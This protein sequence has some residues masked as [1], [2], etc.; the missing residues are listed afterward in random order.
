M[1]KLLSVVLALVMVL[2]TASMLI[3]TAWAE[4]E[5]SAPY[6]PTPRP[7]DSWVYYEQDFDDEALDGLE[8]VALAE[9]IEWTA[10]DASQTMLLKD[11]KLRFVSQYYKAGASTAASAYTTTL[12]AEGDDR[13]LGNMTV[14]EYDLRFQRRAPGAENNVTVNAETT[15]EK[16][17][18]AD[19]QDGAMLVGV[20]MGVSTGM[21]QATRFPVA[22]SISK[23][24]FK[25]T[26]VS[27]SGGNLSYALKNGVE[28]IEDIPE[29]DTSYTLEFGTNKNT[30]RF[31]MDYHVKAVYDP[32]AGMY[33]LTLNGVMVS[34]VA[35]DD[36][37]SGSIR[38]LVDKIT[39]QFVLT[40]ENSADVLLDNIQIY[41][42][43][44]TPALVISEVTP[45]GFGVDKAG[46]IKAGGYQWIELYNPTAKDVNVYDYALH[47]NNAPTTEASNFG[48]NA[49]VTTGRGSA[50]GYFRAGEQTFALGEGTSTFVNPD[51]ADGVLKA[52]ESAIVLLPGTLHAANM[53]LNGDQITKAFVKMGMPEDTKIF[54]CDNY[55]AYP[56]V[57]SKE[58]TMTLGLM[59]VNNPGTAEA[60]GKYVDVSDDRLP[61]L[62][63]YLILTTDEAD[64]QNLYEGI[65]IVSGY[66]PTDSVLGTAKRSVEISYWGFGVD[67][68]SSAM[69]FMK[70]NGTET[71]PG[72]DGEDVYATPGYVGEELRPSVT[73]S[74]YD[75]STGETDTKYGTF[76]SE[77]T[78]EDPERPGY[79]FLGYQ[80]EGSDEYLDGVYMSEN[81]LKVTVAYKRVAPIFV[82]AQVSEMNEGKYTVRLL[83]GLVHGDV[84]GVGFKY[85][86]SYVNENGKTVEVEEKTYLCQYVYTA[87]NVAG[88]PVQADDMG[89]DYLF[90]LHVNN[91]PEAVE[92]IDFKVSVFTIKDKFD[93][94]PVYGEEQLITVP[95]P[96]VNVGA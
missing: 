71:R 76:M 38:H 5:D 95:A 7:A 10:P 56:F 4:I 11:G 23:K 82:G 18:A 59:E 29:S 89:F 9:A 81:G 17:V 14:I 78:L 75:E 91:I 19:G 48:Q 24:A 37:H 47:V 66:I 85:S 6:E 40:I 25:G 31:E 53:S 44:A 87:V 2:A 15:E 74:V 12:I 50:L 93:N 16:V 61:Y 42:C 67:G 60:Q 51:Y 49:D 36:N 52:G 34:K 13:M 63:S 92:S 45:N 35:V 73:I 39:S 46:E 20:D 77:W 64:D 70:I 27:K 72:A 28:L 32:I 94:E 80:L 41:G 88:V 8:D 3:P 65:G 68:S 79:E 33:Y 62:E 57:L 30:S 54:V 58:G 1:K 55:N 21:I 84:D 69:G 86:Y 22:G 43:S 26:G 90:A 96:V 83:G